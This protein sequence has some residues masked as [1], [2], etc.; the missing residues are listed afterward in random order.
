MGILFFGV[1]P[2][3][4]RV[5]WVFSNRFFSSLSGHGAISRSWTLD[6]A[7]SGRFQAQ[8]WDFL[9]GRILLGNRQMPF[10]I[11]MF[12]FWGGEQNAGIFFCFFFLS[13]QFGNIFLA[14]FFVDTRLNRFFVKIISWTWWNQRGV[15]AGAFSCPKCWNLKFMATPDPSKRKRRWR[16][17]GTQIARAKLGADH[18]DTL[19]SVLHFGAMLQAG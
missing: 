4:V 11:S 12:F 16:G 17:V 14:V 2:G 1:F 10:W 19:R 5:R 3:H 9:V 6:T 15:P 8:R 18:P 13:L 7:G